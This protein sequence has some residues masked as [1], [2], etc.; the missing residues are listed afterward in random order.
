M[1]IDDFAKVAFKLNK[2]TQMRLSCSRNLV[3]PLKKKKKKALLLEA[4]TR[5]TLQIANSSN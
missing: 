5:S 1:G 2:T 4:L 3:L